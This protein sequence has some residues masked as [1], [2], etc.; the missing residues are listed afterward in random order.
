MDFGL[1]GG[2]GRR[3]QPLG[4]DLP[5]DQRDQGGLGD[6]VLE[7]DVEGGRRLLQFREIVGDQCDADTRIHVAEPD[8][9]ELEALPLV[10]LGFDGGGGGGDGGGGGIDLGFD[11]GH[12]VFSFV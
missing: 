11:L 9:P 6:V 8:M 3:D 2:L 5:L 7:L 4:G 12:L 1:G 10:H